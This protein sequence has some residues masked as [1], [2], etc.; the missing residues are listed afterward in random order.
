MRRGGGDGGSSSLE[1]AE[2]CS[3]ALGRYCGF[4]V[5]ATVG[6]LCLCRQCRCFFDF[7]EERARALESS[8][9][10]KY[11]IYYTA[12][13]AGDQAN[14]RL[15]LTRK[16]SCSSTVR[17]VLG[18]R[19][20]CAATVAQL[21]HSA[22]P[23]LVILLLLPALLCCVLLYSTTRANLEYTIAAGAQQRSLQPHSASHTP[24]PRRR[25]VATAAATKTAFY[26]VPLMGFTAHL[27]RCCLMPRPPLN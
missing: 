19:A 16:E 7:E 21:S 3:A 1:A 22:R 15:G 9:A 5:M 17:F 6:R 25:A 27:D 20:R 2:P 23:Q 18:S 13:P 14:N 24:L 10:S 12:K 26:A 11:Y 8:L 4:G